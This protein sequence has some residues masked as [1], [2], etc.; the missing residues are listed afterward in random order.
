M[1]IRA[2]SKIGRSQFLH[3]AE[4]VRGERTGSDERRATRA[5]WAAQPVS[6]NR[7]IHQSKAVSVNSGGRGPGGLGES[8]DRVPKPVQVVLGP[9]TTTRYGPAV[10]PQ[11]RRHRGGH[12]LFRTWSAAQTRLRSESSRIPRQFI[13]PN[14]CSRK[15][16]RRGSRRAQ[17]SSTAPTADR[18]P[19]GNRPLGTACALRRLRAA[20]ARVRGPGADMRRPGAPRPR[21]DG[22]G[23]LSSGRTHR[24]AHRSTRVAGRSRRLPFPPAA[25]GEPGRAF[26]S[27]LGAGPAGAPSRPSTRPAGSFPAHIVRRAVPVD[28][29]H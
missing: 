19:S 4:R 29:R 13:S 15:L 12:R 18:A 24:M 9:S 5:S 10:V 22:T 20:S 23:I 26:R 21:A 16:C 2:E 7:M 3:Q 17:V 11:V 6:W 27:A 14:R 25:P 28:Q 8:C 1:Q